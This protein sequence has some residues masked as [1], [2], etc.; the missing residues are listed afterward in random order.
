LK[1]RPLIWV[2]DTTKAPQIFGG[3]KKGALKRAFDELEIKGTA[4]RGHASVYTAKKRL[5]VHMA[6]AF[7]L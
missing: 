1:W 6:A 5:C 4:K 3:I 7:I 2:E